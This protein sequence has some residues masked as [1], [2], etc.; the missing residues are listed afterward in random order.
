MKSLLLGVTLLIAGNFV[1]SNASAAAGSCCPCTL[2][3]ASCHC[4]TEPNCGDAV[5][6]EAQILQILKIDPTAKR[7]SFK[8]DIKL[9]R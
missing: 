8:K 7:Q 3:G 1:S 5:L 6:S 2:G 4:G 9:K